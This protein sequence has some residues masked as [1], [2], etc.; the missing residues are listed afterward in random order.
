MISASHLT[1]RSD[2]EATYLMK[3]LDLEARGRKQGGRDI[4]RPGR[5]YFTNH[6]YFTAE[7]RLGDI[8]EILPVAHIG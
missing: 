7:V 4:S 1:F 6:C 8:L 2:V 3:G 5:I